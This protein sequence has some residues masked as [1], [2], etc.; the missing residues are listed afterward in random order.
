MLG[1]EAYFCSFVGFSYACIP[2]VEA[3]QIREKQICPRAADIQCL[4]DIQ[5]GLKA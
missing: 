5:R 3:K 1:E 2:E 4:T